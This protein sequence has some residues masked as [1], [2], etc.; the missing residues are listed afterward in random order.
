[1]TGPHD[2]HAPGSVLLHSRRS[3][4][5]A[6]GACKVA[7]IPH[8]RIK[9]VTETNPHLARL[10]WL[11]T[12][13]DG[14]IQ[15]AWITCLG[16]RSAEQHLAHLICE[17]YIR[18]KVIGAADDSGFVLP[19]TQVELADALGISSVHVNRV[20]QE[21]R[22]EQL[23]VWKGARVDIVNWEKLSE[24]AEFDTRYLHLERE[25]R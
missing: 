9:E 3:I 2:Q 20:L 11:S 1:M 8:G 10:F 12:T 6:L 23:V 7:F 19:I 4:V 5:V 17:L 22:D 21:M 15:R 16:R 13:I 25:P 24:A 18:L 14:A